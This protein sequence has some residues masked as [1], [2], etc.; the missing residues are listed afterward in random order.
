MKLVR[1]GL[2]SR[3]VLELASHYGSQRWLRNLP[4]GD[5]HPVI[6]FPGFLTSGYS[7]GPLRRTLA[8]LGYEVHDWGFGR[9]LRYSDELEGRMQA[10]VEERHAASGKKVSLVGWSLGGVFAR[11]IARARPELVRNVISLGSPITGTKHVTLAGPI[12]EFLNGDLDPELLA[13]IESMRGPPPVPSSVIYSRS[14]GV[15]HWH[16]AMQHEAETAENIHVPASH[17]GMGANP[18]VLSVIADRLQQ[19]EG[20][21][22]PFKVSGAQRMIYRANKPVV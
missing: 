13:R 22:K 15:V 8:Q 10:M 6:V 16:G 2:E 18:F 4:K 7:T 11:E 5:G 14:D 17:V 19:T 20:G 12:Y 9:N 3:W 1:M 21:W